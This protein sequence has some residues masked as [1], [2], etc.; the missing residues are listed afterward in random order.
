MEV[1]GLERPT[2]L[3]SAVFYA[4]CAGLVYLGWRTLTSSA[5]SLLAQAGGVAT[6]L[7]GLIM[8][9]LVGNGGIVDDRNAAD[10]KAFIDSRRAQQGTA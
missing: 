7:F 2:P 6:G 3:A 4:L 10:D 5:G 8:L 9:F 1:V